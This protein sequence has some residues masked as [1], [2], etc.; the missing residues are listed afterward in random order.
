MWHWRLR[1]CQLETLI[2]RVGIGESKDLGCGDRDGMRFD[3]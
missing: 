1:Y 2:D 3:E